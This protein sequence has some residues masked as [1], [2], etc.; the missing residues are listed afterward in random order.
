LAANVAALLVEAGARVGAVDF[1]DDAVG[2]P[3][4]FGLAPTTF[5]DRLTAYFWGRIPIEETAVDV[6]TTMAPA[7]MGGRLFIVPSVLWREWLAPGG[8]STLDQGV[9]KDA[10]RRVLDRLALDWLVVEAGAGLADETLLSAASADILIEVARR[11]AQ[12]LQAT[13]VMLG[14]AERLG[15]RR[16]YL[17]VSQSPTSASA[18]RLR[19]EFEAAY[20]VPVAAVLPLAPELAQP[21]GGELLALA[22]PAHPWSVAVRRLVAR[23]T[24]DRSAGQRLGSGESTP[25]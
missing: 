18:A 14:L 6:T 16:I 17:A 5:D 15:A 22:Q 19:R 25:S 7:A 9:F 23:L 2:I 21:E 24:A 8:P 4:L 10:I 11:D 12:D 1:D 20:G 3:A 13:A